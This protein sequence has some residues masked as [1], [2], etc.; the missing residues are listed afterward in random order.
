[1]AALNPPVII[2]VR[3]QNAGNLGAMARAM[4]NFGLSELRIVGERPT[5]DATEEFSKMDWAMACKG[6]HVLES[7]KIYS[8]LSEALS[9]CHSALGTSGKPDDYDLGYSRPFVNPKEAF[10]N[11][12]EESLAFSKKSDFKWALVF[13]CE[14]D[15]LSAEDVSHCKQLVQ[16]QSSEKSP[17]INLAMAA[18]LLIYHFHLLNCEE[19]H[20]IQSDIHGE[21]HNDGAAASQ[22]IFGAYELN[23]NE[24]WSTLGEK[25]RFIEYLVETLKLTQFFKYPDDLSV[26][27]RF[28]RLFQSLPMPRGELL[29]AFEALYQLKSWGE[30][31]FE[32]RNFLK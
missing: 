32:K 14:S 21:I 26:A 28:R 27:G 17:S 20:E 12:M 23:K 3:P 25:E 13:G 6:E 8:H 7:A 30:G 15:G 2:S 9:D 18:G 5:T 10:K 4:S 1:M 19:H 29:L 11:L 31:K 22:A 24:S 16:I